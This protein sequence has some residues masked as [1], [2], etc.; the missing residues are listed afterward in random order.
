MGWQDELSSL[1][2]DLSAGRIQAEEYRRRR[3]ELLAAA[4]SSSIEVRRMHRKQGPSIAN[5]FTG[6]AKSIDTSANTTQRA[7]VPD[8]PTAP[9]D[10][11]RPPAKSNWQVL[12]PAPQA[13]KPSGPP[14]PQ[15]RPSSAQPPM[16]GSEVF[17]P[18]A[19]GPPTRRI[20]PRYVIAVVVLA[21]V[22]GLTWWLVFRPGNITAAGPTPSSQPRSQPEQQAPTPQVD[23]QLSVEKLPNPTD[24]PLS[25]SGELTVDQAQLYNMIRPDEAGYLVE[26]GTE[27]IFCRTVTS[28]NLSYVLFAFQTEDARGGEA[29][30]KRIVERNKGL[31]MTDAALPG[32]PAEV[33]ALTVVGE[34]STLSEAI[35]GNGKVTVRIVI[36]QTSPGDRSQL[37]N[38]VRRSID[39][40]TKSISVK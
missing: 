29:L 20:W 27:K 12:Q 9:A 38:A 5:A 19:A 22:A 10:A 13:R 35:Y 6:D 3:D 26:A 25:T 8:E 7:G 40:T 34:K 2:E 39:L 21:L 1:D 32:L 24:L 15:P 11:P 23:T 37:N 31:G 18:G 17:G 30:A 14:Q 33:T 28:G 16:Q 36:Q 4:S